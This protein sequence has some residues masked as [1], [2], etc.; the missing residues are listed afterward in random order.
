VR[1]TRRRKT[2]KWAVNASGTNLLSTPQNAVPMIK[3][4]EKLH[5]VKVAA[6]F[7]KENV[8][9]KRKVNSLTNYNK[10]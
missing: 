2:A 7:L 3:D 1:I 9:G 8:K 5:I 10:K 4:Q 6:K